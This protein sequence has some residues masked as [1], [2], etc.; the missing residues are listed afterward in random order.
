MASIE[1]QYDEAIELQEAGELEGA[2]GKLQSLLDQAPEYALASAALS[3]FYSKLGRHQEAVDHAQK[4]CDLEPDD[5][6]SF[7]AMSLICQKAGRLA[8]AE[9]A[10][11]AAME[12]QWAA[13]RKPGG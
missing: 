13:M 8:E 4:V 3:V 10:L 2:V 7:V 9:Q 5:P 12:K 1:Q 6:F 11:G